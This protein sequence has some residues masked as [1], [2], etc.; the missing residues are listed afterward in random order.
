[1]SMLAYIL[2]S[3]LRNPR[4]T[5]AYL[6]GTVIAVGLASELNSFAGEYAEEPSRDRKVEAS[7]GYRIRVKQGKSAPA[8]FVIGNDTRGV[9]FGIGHLLRVLR[10]KSDGETRRTHQGSG[11]RRRR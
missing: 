3:I 4:P 6:I 9:L 8:V 11:A 10:M 1:M 5:A 7:E 2:P